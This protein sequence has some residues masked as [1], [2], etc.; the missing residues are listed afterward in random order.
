MP[1]Q[2]VVG[3]A[4]IEFW[5]QNGHCPHVV[6]IAD[7]NGRRPCFAYMSRER[8]EERIDDLAFFWGT[9]W[10]EKIEVLRP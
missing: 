7:R 8:A 4:R 6:V 3:T 1:A 2:T 5:P 10:D 9:R